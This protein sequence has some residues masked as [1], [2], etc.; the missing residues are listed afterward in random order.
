MTGRRRSPRNSM[1]VRMSGCTVGGSDVLYKEERVSRIMEPA[2]R[3]S[4]FESFKYLY[5]IFKI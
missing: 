2:D 4:L 3:Y 1:R 5:I